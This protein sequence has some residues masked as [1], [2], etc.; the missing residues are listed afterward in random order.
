MMVCLSPVVAAA[1]A[2]FDSK[3]DVFIDRPIGSDVGII[4]EM[5]FV[6][7]SDA[8][9]HEERRT[10]PSDAQIGFGEGLRKGAVAKETISVEVCSKGW[11]KAGL[12]VGKKGIAPADAKLVEL[13]VAVVDIE[14]IMVA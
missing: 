5:F 9:A 14:V 13:V 1:M 6:I 12:L 8:A 7:P 11:Q 4:P 2:E 10:V 3:G